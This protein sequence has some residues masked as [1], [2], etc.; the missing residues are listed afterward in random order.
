MISIGEQEFKVWNINE[1]FMPSGLKNIGIRKF[2]FEP[3]DQ[4]PWTFDKLSY[5]N[6]ESYLDI[7]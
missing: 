5:Y 3:S 6:S 2:E 1:M 7:I 4:F